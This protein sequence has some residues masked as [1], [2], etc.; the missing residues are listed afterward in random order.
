MSFLR[1]SFQVTTITELKQQ[2]RN[3][4]CHLHQ[5][6]TTFELDSR[7]PA[8]NKWCMYSSKPLRYSIQKVHPCHVVC[9]HLLKT[10][11]DISLQSSCLIHYYSNGMTVCHYLL[12]W[13]II[14]TVYRI[15]KILP[16][17][18]HELSLPSKCRPSS[19]ASTSVTEAWCCFFQGGP[20]GLQLFSCVA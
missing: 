17:L 15:H 1:H 2:T 13:N 20:T 3:R 9:H 5:Q 8:W 7:S 6:N 18:Q 14:C 10:I 4:A 11:I 19:R 16:L 12:H